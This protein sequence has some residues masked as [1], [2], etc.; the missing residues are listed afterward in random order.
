MTIPHMT[1]EM[2][3]ALIGLAVYGLYRLIVDIL[4]ASMTHGTKY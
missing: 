1:G 4:T 2:L 3:G